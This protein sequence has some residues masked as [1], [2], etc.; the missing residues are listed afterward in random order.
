MFYVREC[1]RCGRDYKNTI[2]HFPGKYCP[3][4]QDK[5]DFEIQNTAIDDFVA[6]F[7]AYLDKKYDRLAD[8]ER[9]EMQEFAEKWKQEK[10]NGKK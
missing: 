10:R 6:N 9:A 2:K 4:C 7:C 1:K 8:D 5:T 3:E